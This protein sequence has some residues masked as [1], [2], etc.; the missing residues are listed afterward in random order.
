MEETKHKTD[1]KQVKKS[2][3]RKIEPEPEP[4]QNGSVE[5]DTTVKKVR[6]EILAKDFINDFKTFIRIHD[7]V[8][9]KSDVCLI[10]R[11]H[12]NKIEKV[13]KTN[14]EGKKE[15][16]KQLIGCGR[17]VKMSN[18]FHEFIVSGKDAGH[19]Q[20]IRIPIRNYYNETDCPQFDIDLL[21]KVSILLL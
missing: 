21:K 10:Q 19:S 1:K 11:L 3:K 5:N 9:K 15:I 2:K 18:H 14:K 12:I 6:K 8:I 20:V 4:E 17:G 16:V 13:E 7:L